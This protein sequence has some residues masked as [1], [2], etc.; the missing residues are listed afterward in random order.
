MNLLRSIKSRLHVMCLATFFS[1]GSDVLY[2]AD[3]KKLQAIFKD[4]MD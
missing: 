4:I 3:E 1:I 2:F